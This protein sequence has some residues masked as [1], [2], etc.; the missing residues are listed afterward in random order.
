[1]N[2]RNTLIFIRLSRRESYRDTLELVKLVKSGI[3]FYE[4][5]AVT[6]H[7]A[8]YA[9]SEEERKSSRHLAEVL[10]DSVVTLRL[11]MEF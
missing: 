8:K 7:S 3:T 11:N 1:M 6:L 10:L 9:T 4:R 2:R 5:T